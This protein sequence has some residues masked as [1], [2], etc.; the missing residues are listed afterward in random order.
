M[1]KC[2]TSQSA[3][4]AAAVKEAVG[5][6]IEVLGL[7]CLNPAVGGINP[8]AVEHAIKMGVKG[9]WMP[10]MWADNNVQYVKERKSAM[11]DESIGTVFGDKGVTIV[12]DDGH[13]KPELVEILK[14][15]EQADIM[16]ATGHISCQDAHLLLDEANKVG[17]KKLVVHT[18][19]YHTMNY[20]IPDLDKMVKVN[21]AYLEFG[22]SSLPNPIWMPVDMDR[23]WDLERICKAIRTVGAEHCILSTDSGQFTTASPIECVRM[24]GEIL[25]A[26]GFKREEIDLMTKV[27]PA[28]VLGLDEMES[29]VIAANPSEGST[30]GSV[31]T[32]GLDNV[33]TFDND[34][35]RSA[36]GRYDFPWSP[37]NLRTYEAL[38]G[39]IDIHVHTHP[40]TMPRLLTDREAVA[41]AKAVKMRA[42]LL[43]CHTSMT[44]DRAAGAKE[45]V[46]GG[47]EVFGA[48]CLNPAV[49]GIN[50]AAVEHA[51]NMGVKA[52]WMP[53]LW[54]D[55]HVKYV[56]TSKNKMG[57]E[58][59]GVEF[60]ETGVSIV[61]D[62]GKIKPE[63][64]EILE[65]T[66]DA[67]IMLAT[68]NVSCEDAHLLLDEANRVGVKK[69]VVTTV[70]DH[71][72]NYPLDDLKR[73][74]DYNGAYL[75]IGHR[76]LPF[77]FW[78][79]SA[80]PE[81]RKAFDDTCKIIR[82]VGP[83]HCILSS[84]SGQLTSASPIE[85][86]RMWF[87]LLKVRGFSREETDVMTKVNPAKVLGL[88]DTE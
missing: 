18:C 85:C 60:G 40:D 64:I 58:T 41:Q 17:V 5:G 15:C 4:R 55:H 75:E 50:P 35:D 54:S 69:L 79:E 7:I 33:T 46:E 59:L 38:A 84:D 13:I 66:A 87:E 88:D 10:S 23:L 86:M 43:K 9:V 83:E 32:N 76:S 80:D 68:G 62:S 45:A 49:D 42:V 61:T 29:H 63:L 20:P 3:A 52:V 24:W 67:G 30:N 16:L 21:G 51:I 71:V 72:T 6:G 26:K 27:N 14:M 82:D 39:A 11:G 47:I 53:T 36:I 73:M 65:M 19:N 57:Y 31:H 44:A 34:E 28:K 74:V 56:N 77:P 78:W 25:M 48:I 2:H 8:A 81:R 37:L 22:F 1:I 70:N 12:T